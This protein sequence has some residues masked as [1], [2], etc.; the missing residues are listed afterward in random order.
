MN[1][2]RALGGDSISVWRGGTIREKTVT[3]LAGYKSL[4]DASSAQ[5]TQSCTY[6]P[7]STPLVRK[8]VA[9]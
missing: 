7:M 6:D 9:L 1:G 2:V 8:H 3:I 5:S 4:E